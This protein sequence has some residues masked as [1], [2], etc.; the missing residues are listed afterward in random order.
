MLIPDLVLIGSSLDQ[1]IRILTQRA[2]REFNPG[3]FLERLGLLSPCGQD[4]LAQLNG[5]IHGDGVSS[6][7][8]KSA[9]QRGQKH[10]Y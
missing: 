6:F 9:I 4:G 10:F 7:G 3:R 1:P 8:Y 2:P 5:V